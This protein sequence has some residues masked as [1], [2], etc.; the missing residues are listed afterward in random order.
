MPPEMKDCIKEKMGAD[1]F[2]K[3]EKGEDVEIGPE[4]EGIIQ[5]CTGNI[6]GMVEN[7]ME[8]AMEQVPPEMRGCVQEKLGN[9]AEKIKSG[10]VKE[11][12]IP[13]LIQECVSSMIPKDIPKMPEGMNIPSDISIPKDIPSAKDIES[14]KELQKQYQDMPQG[15]PSDIPQGPPANIPQGPPENIPTPP[16][17]M[18]QIPTSIPQMTGAPEAQGPSCDQFIAVPDCSFVPSSVQSI[19]KQCKGQ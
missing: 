15:P 8:Q 2:G 9:I 3:I 1:K 18:P 11:S 13:G 12:D 6:E 10:E 14:L 5:G 17:E 16:A 7:K 19:C 4:I